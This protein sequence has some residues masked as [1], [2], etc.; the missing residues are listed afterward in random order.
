MTKILAPLLLAALL[1]P[2]FAADQPPKDANR[3]LF[4]SQV[5]GYTKA[6]DQGLVLTSG[7]RDWQVD[8]AT[9][10]SGL[11]FAQTV[12]VKSRT[13]CVTAG[14]SIRFRE[15]RGIVQSC[16]IGKISYLPKPDMAAEPAT[17]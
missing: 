8:L 1:T 9:R 7:N 13:T 15:A 2:A 10:C 14:D 17:D 5:D 16:M 4:S 6:T 3:C 11:R 12:G